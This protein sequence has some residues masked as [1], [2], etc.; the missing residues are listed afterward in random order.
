MDMRRNSEG[1]VG[2]ECAPRWGLTFLT[3]TPVRSSSFQAKA[4][5]EG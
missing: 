3:P 4:G 5:S 1:R 2:G